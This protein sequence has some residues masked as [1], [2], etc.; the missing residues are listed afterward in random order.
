[1]TADW[2]Y[3][4]AV[5]SQDAQ[6]LKAIIQQSFGGSLDDCDRY[7][8]RIGMENFRLLHQGEQAIAVSAIYH[9]G[10]WYEGQIV[11]MAGIAA[12]GVAPE[13]RGQRVAY[14]LLR[15]T[16]EELYR[17]QVPI[18]VLY[19]ATQI[20]YRKVGYEQA[21]S[22]CKWELPTTNMGRH[23]SHLTMRSASL[24]DR[25]IFEAIY[26]RQARVNNGNLA[27]H[28]AIWEQ[29]IESAKE[30]PIYAYLI[31]SES[32]PEG[33]IIFTQRR[34]KKEF[35]LDIHDWAILTASAAKRLW[36]FIASHRSQIH[37][38][39]WHGAFFNPFMLF[40]PEQTAKIAGQMIWMLRIIDVSAALSK[41]GYPTGLEAELHLDIQDELLTANNGK[42]CLKVS[43]GRGE[44]TPGGKG[45]LQ[46]NIRSL[47]SL[48]SG[49][50]SPQ[51]LQLLGYL[52]ASTEDL[53]MARLTFSGDRPWMA[54]FF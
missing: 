52:N 45:T 15:R 28:P 27:R 23:E 5:H 43:G 48:Y 12:V 30:Q 11:P 3:R 24:S 31:G 8:N 21:G 47:A 10:Q 19:P 44:I 29:I 18:S 50:L 2:E 35:L 17:L 53:E 49:F 1:M 32:E 22:Y 51:Q 9:M 13:H 39:C 36:T 7:F 38:V 33:Y 34:E 4:S 37:K 40:L 54:D 14:E 25:S 46:L 6:Q 26:N 42:F 16:I 20:L 41:R